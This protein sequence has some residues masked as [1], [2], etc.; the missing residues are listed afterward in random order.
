MF[1]PQIAG[2]EFADRFRRKSLQGK[3]LR[4]RGRATNAI[5]PYHTRVYVDLSERP[6]LRG[7]GGLYPRLILTPPTDS[8]PPDPSPRCIG[9]SEPIAPSRTASQK[10]GHGLSNTRSQALSCPCTHGRVWFIL[11][12]TTAKSIVFP[13]VL[14]ELTFA[15]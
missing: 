1:P 11:M 14:G 7:C 3:G 8:Q 13:S 4:R 6:P 12:L 5:S 15:C 9:S 10:W 2:T